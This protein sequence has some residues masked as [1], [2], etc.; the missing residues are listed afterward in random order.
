MKSRSASRRVARSQR[1]VVLFVALIVLV[2]MTM[3]GLALLRQMGAGTSIAGNVAFK[4]NATSVADLGVE[5]G[6]EYILAH[7]NALST[8]AETEG[9]YSNW[10]ASVDPGSFN[11]DTAPLLND[12]FAVTGNDT[13]Y[14]IHRLCQFKDTPANAAGQNCSDGAGNFAGVSLGGGCGYGCP[15]FTPLPGPYYRVTARVKGPRNTYS[16]VQVVMN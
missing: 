8:S 13:R 15:S 10:S 4:E 7:K 3:A 2:V 1:G 9:Y 14:V 5:K 12:D 11:W 16:Y 6:R